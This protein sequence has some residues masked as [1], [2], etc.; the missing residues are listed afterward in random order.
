M[1]QGAFPSPAGFYAKLLAC[2]SFFPMLEPTPLYGG[3]AAFLDALHEQYLLDPASVGERW[4]TYF[5]QLA[6][7]GAERAH[8]PI[9]AEGEA[10]S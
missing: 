7:A 3:N 9:R 6:P 2:R 4:R 5:A 8:G 1:P 10:G